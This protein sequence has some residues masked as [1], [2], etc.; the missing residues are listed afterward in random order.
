MNLLMCTPLMDSKGK[1]RYFLGAQI[2]VSGLAKECAGLEYLKRHVEDQYEG[3]NEEQMNNGTPESGEGKE[4]E[5]E[6]KDEFQK[7]SEMFNLQE[8]D[9]VRKHGVAMHRPLQDQ[10]QTSAQMAQ[11]TARDRV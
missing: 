9:T 3:D 1:V 6:A 4:P 5:Q 10:E 7:L 8:L 11:G 2:D